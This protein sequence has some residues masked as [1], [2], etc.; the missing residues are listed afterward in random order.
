MIEKFTLMQRF[1]KHASSIG[2][3]KR[4]YGAIARYYTR[5]FGHHHPD[6]WERDILNEQLCDLLK[7]PDIGRKNAIVVLNVAADLMREK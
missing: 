6:D 3:A 5:K 2:Q 1:E 4:A 7:I